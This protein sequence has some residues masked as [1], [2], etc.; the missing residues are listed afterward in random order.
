MNRQVR[1]GA[2]LRPAEP[3]LFREVQ[4]FHHWFFWLPIIVVVGVIWWQFIQQVIVGRPPGTEPIAD[5]AAWVLTLVFG[6]GFPVF[7][8]VVR[9]V[10]EVSP[11]RLSVRLVPFSG[12]VVATDDIETAYAREYSPMREFGG[13]GVRLGADGGRAYNA[14]GKEGVQLVLKDG[15]HILV[16]TQRADEL[17]GALRSAGA[18]VPP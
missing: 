14:H 9:L 12:R 4:R 13:W 17:I 6:I 11:G 5:W 10:T 3:P 1:N 15:R 8:A 2:T 16:G 7:A 18:K